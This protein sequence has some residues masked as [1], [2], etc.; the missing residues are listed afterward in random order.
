[1]TLT[2]MGLTMGIM[3]LVFSI[4]GPAGHLCWYVTDHPGGLLRKIHY[5]IIWSAITCVAVGML[6]IY[7]DV[8]TKDRAMEKFK[9]H[10]SV[11]MTPEELKKKRKAERRSGN[12]RKAAQ[13]AGLLVGA[14]YLTWTFSTVSYNSDMT[15]TIILG[16]LKQLLI[17]IS[18][19]YILGTLV[20]PVQPIGTE[21]TRDCRTRPNL[22]IAGS[23]S[24]IPPSA[25]LLKCLY[26]LPPSLQKDK[27][28][29]SQL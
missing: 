25:G 12:A 3:G 8:R 10:R 7:W 15:G 21:T 4:F 20:A 26:L 2:M 22:H 9:Y 18:S 28:P 27:N 13:H 17:I 14:M 19:A 6:L 16:F 1:M 24:H 23:L 29:K 11:D 5:G